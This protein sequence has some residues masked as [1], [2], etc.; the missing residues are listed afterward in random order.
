MAE[1]MC[2]ASF[3]LQIIDNYLFQYKTRIELKNSQG[4][5]NDAKFFENFAQ[6]I[7]QHWFGVPFEN[8][9][10]DDGQFPVADLIS[11]DG[12]IFVQV[13][14]QQDIKAKIDET[15][16]TLGKIKSKK[17]KNKKDQILSSVSELYFFV[18]DNRSVDKVEDFTN[19]ETGIR[20]SKKNHLITTSDLSSKAAENADFRNALFKL[21]KNDLDS[22]EDSIH[23]IDGAIRDS[24]DLLQQIK[25]TIGDDFS[26]DRKDLIEDVLKSKAR[27]KIIAGEAGA[28]K[29][30]LC[31]KL[32]EEWET[33]G[34]IVLACRSEKLKEVKSIDDIWGFKVENILCPTNNRKVFL[35]V[36]G[37]EFIANILTKRD[38]VYSLCELTKNNENLNILLSCRTRDLHCFRFL[39]NL[40]SSDVIKVPPLTQDETRKAIEANKALSQYISGGKY[41][42]FLSSPFYLDFLASIQSSSPLESYRDIRSS[43]WEQLVCQNR[44]DKQSSFNNLD[45][46][47]TIIDMTRWRAEH[48]TLGANRDRYNS[49]I[50]EY[51]ISSGVVKEIGNNKQIRLSCDIFEDICF[52]RQFDELFDES[53][54]DF[55]VF[56]DGVKSFGRCAPRQYRNWLHSRVVEDDDIEFALDIVSAKDVPQFW[57]NQTEIF[58][59]SGELTEKAAEKILANGGDDS[60]LHFAEIC[61]VWAFIP[62]KETKINKL[63]LLPIGTMRGAIIK[64]IDEKSFK[65]WECSCLFDLFSDSA[66]Q[67]DLSSEA[68]HS[69]TELC[70]KYID[71]NLN[72]YFDMKEQ[73]ETILRILLTFPNE[74][75]EWLMAFFDKIQSL[76]Y[77]GAVLDSRTG[78]EIID[79]I[80]E[81]NHPE[82][83]KSYGKDVGKIAIRY[84]T[85]E[86]KYKECMRHYR[87]T[88]SYG[89]F[90][91]ASSVD[92]YDK[93]AMSRPYGDAF[94]FLYFLVDFR[95]ALAF[96]IDLFNVVSK[97]SAFP[98]IEIQIDGR[99]KKLYGDEFLWTINSESSLSPSILGSALFCAKIGADSCISSLQSQEDRRTFVKEME[100]IISK[101]SDSIAPFDILSYV[102]RKRTLYEEA[103]VLYSSP[104]LLYLDSI[105]NIKDNPG[106]TIELQKRQL[107]EAMGMPF[108]ASNNRYSDLADAKN[109]LASLFILYQKEHPEIKF[110][111]FDEIYRVWGAANNQGDFVKTLD[112]DNYNIRTADNGI[113]LIPKDCNPEPNDDND[114]LHETRIS[115]LFKEARKIGDSE[116]FNITRYI[117]IIN[118]LKTISQSEIRALALECYL[119][120]SC[121]FIVRDDVDD[122]VKEK[123]IED[124]VEEAEKIEYEGSFARVPLLP[125]LLTRLRHPIK[126]SLK[127]RI[128]KLLFHK[129]FSLSDD[130]GIYVEIDTL[131]RTFNANPDLSE[132]LLQY[133]CE[134]CEI[135]QQEPEAFLGWSLGNK[136]LAIYR[137]RG[138]G[139]SEEQFKLVD[140][141][142]DKILCADEKTIA[143][144][145]TNLSLDSA[146]CLF[147]II[148]GCDIEKQLS[149]LRNWLPQYFEKTKENPDCIP[150]IYRNIF[151]NEISKMLVES[152]KNGYEMLDILFN[153]LPKDY[154]KE[155]GETFLEI[156]GD[157]P[158]ICFDSWK[159]PNEEEKIISFLAR[160]QDAISKRASSPYKDVLARIASFAPSKYSNLAKLMEFE[161]HISPEL[162][163]AM[164]KIMS[165]EGASHLDYVMNTM[166]CFHL[167]QFMPKGIICID[168]I[169]KRNDPRSLEIVR[170]DRSGLFERIITCCYFDYSDEIRAKQ[171]LSNSYISVLRMAG[172]LGKSYPLVLLDEFESR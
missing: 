119:Q 160:L 138:F 23:H 47:K 52:E 16:E 2:K 48:F 62:D 27:I 131:A 87:E 99:T 103:R 35:Y 71:D 96:V 44:T 1:K 153:S 70:R 45:I 126:K 22:T 162:Q 24:G 8:L 50:I 143:K 172:N 159:S 97:K 74:S 73:F 92:K 148:R 78:E 55:K 108:L 101:T 26:L 42:A 66:R 100:D 60:L 18:L 61:N 4:L 41:K 30:A 93:G 139:V 145:L 167:D 155:V 146:V 56:F 118:E 6:A 69:L 169:L 116:P 81:G 25:T 80:I 5:N 58:L 144:D 17:K 104:D 39:T 133:G 76:Y 91:M 164:L 140:E 165:K 36:D 135:A 86:P 38:L 151:I 90:K 63:N 117:E 112:A 40:Y 114:P 84:W 21:I 127:C 142:I 109:D 31:R 106:P 11:K 57:K 29:S 156:F 53:C 123:I 54:G 154:S 166:V 137:Q 121:A 43:I 13:S 124:L 128:R 94:F 89:H 33:Q 132:P 141:E 129:L 75:K 130:G 105:R 125:I 157:I 134:I 171:K 88:S 68:V 115:T 158:Y 111:G 12:K 82:L 77:E 59:C 15:F 20:F 161:S 98:T 102:C 79:L 120:T 163:D 95:A 34:D 170:L 14:T 9:N 64:T 149:L 67:K 107:F 28:G 3:K 83:I 49:A 10:K 150:D 19:E 72:H 122:N 46:K 37:L 152:V 65:W 32:C 51:L 85:E 147:P 136:M 7:C 168:E 110:G 113:V